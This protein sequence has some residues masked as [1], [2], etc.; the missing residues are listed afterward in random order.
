MTAIARRNGRRRSSQRVPRGGIALEFKTSAYALRA[1]ARHVSRNPAFRPVITAW[2]ASALS[3][4]TRER[5]AW[6]APWVVPVPALRAGGCASSRAPWSGRFSRL[7]YVELLRLT[8]RV[9]PPGA[10][11]PSLV[12][13]PSCRVVTEPPWTLRFNVP[14]G[15]AVSVRFA[16]QPDAGLQRLSCWATPQSGVLPCQAHA[17]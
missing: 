13:V 2:V 11:A 5:G 1:S 3:P 8:R 7:G 9:S 4:Q 6:S 16:S 15:N 14:G 17:S 12:P 10:L